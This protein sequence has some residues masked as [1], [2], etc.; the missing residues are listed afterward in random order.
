MWFQR[1][2]LWFNILWYLCDNNCTQTTSKSTINQC[3]KTYTTMLSTRWPFNGKKKIFHLIT[4]A[5]WQFPFNPVF[6]DNFQ[7][8]F[9]TIKYY[10]Y[11]NIWPTTTWCN[12]VM[13]WINIVH[14][15]FG[16]MGFTINISKS[17]SD[18]LMVSGYSW[19]FIQRQTTSFQ[20]HFKI[21]RWHIV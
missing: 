9:T 13:A 4:P 8:F 14:T 5:D 18:C 3:F 16:I 2:P 1:W 12:M 11:D 21:N 10:C 6:Y 20:K 7:L 19:Y 15:F 17:Y